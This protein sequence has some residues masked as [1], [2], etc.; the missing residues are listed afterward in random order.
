MR[1]T[2]KMIS[3]GI[4]HNLNK[5]TARFLNLQRMASSGKRINKPSDDPLGITKDLSFRSR[6]SDIRQFTLNVTHSQSWLTFSDQALNDVND[7]VIKAKDLAVQLG[8]DTYD[9]S[10]R[11]AGATEAWEMFNQMLDAVN[12][13][14]Q[15]KFIF[16]GSRTDLASMAANEIGVQTKL[17][18]IRDAP[19]SFHLQP[20]QR[21]L[22]PEVIDLFDK[23]LKPNERTQEP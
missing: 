21:D 23:H 15:G 8:N 7:L 3:D 5:S 9:E 14:F 20:K 19:H 22:R 4:L 17:I 2:N 6:L 16:S 13:Q 12:T 10:A 1:V 18:I 11:T